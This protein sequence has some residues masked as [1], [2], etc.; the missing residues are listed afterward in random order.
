MNYTIQIL[1][2]LE[3]AE[4]HYSIWKENKLIYLLPNLN[5]TGQDLNWVFFFC[6]CVCM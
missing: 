1:N 4:S 6:V 2:G 3:N 5:D